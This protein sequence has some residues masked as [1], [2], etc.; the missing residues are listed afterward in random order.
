MTTIH[1]LIS[2]GCIFFNYISRQFWLR[3]RQRLCATS[4]HI[5]FKNTTEDT[6]KG[7]YF[8]R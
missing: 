1:T 8:D 7:E 4:S 3:S 2:K 5:I 6:I